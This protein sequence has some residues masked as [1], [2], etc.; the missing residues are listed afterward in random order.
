VG[1]CAGD[2]GATVEASGDLVGVAWGGEDTGAEGKGDF[3]SDPHADRASSATRSPA[4][5]SVIPTSQDR[6]RRVSD[7]PDSESVTARGGRHRADP[8]LV[9]LG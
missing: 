9:R 2:F 5:L 1:V 4:H 6:I 3:T 7:G 8:L